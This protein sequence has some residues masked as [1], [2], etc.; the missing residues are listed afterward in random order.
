MAAQRLVVIGG[1]AAGMSAASQARRFRT[2]DELEIVA[3]ER[4]HFA[5]YSACGIPYWIGGQVAG[6]DELIARTPEEHRAR[7]ID[8][9]MRTEVVEIDPDRGRVR[10]RN[11]ES[12]A[13]S[14]TGWDRLVIATG[15]RPVRPPIPGIGAPGVHGV[16]NLDDGQALLGTLET[17]G[18]P[19]GAQ[20]RRR[21]VVVG[22]G[23]I[24]VE[25]AEA[26]LNRGFEVTVLNR[27]EQP[28]ATLDPDM[29]RL[30]HTAMDGLGITTVNRAEV[31]AIRTGDDGR[32]RAVA[33][34]DAEYPADVV[35]LG[36]GVAPE[37]TLARAAGLPTGEHGGLLTDLSMRVRG[38]DAI[39][40]GGDCVEV[41]DLVSG[42]D[43]YIPLGTHANK[44]G[45][46]IGANIGGGYGT[47]P[48]VVGT[49]VSKVC[50]LEIARTGLREK[51]AAAAGL[52]YVTATVES[53]SRAGY[54]P[55][56]SEMT[57][58]ILAERGAG[59][60]LG[61]QIVGR[62]GAAKR[63]D[64]AAV[65]LTA[66][67]TVERMTLLDLGYAPPFSPVWDPVLVAARK[68]VSALT[69]D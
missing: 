66:G 56:A 24:G 21:A 1:D 67:M 55:D 51:D 2:P 23:Y 63:V 40:A 47:F 65:A 29:G 34:A 41:L 10:T 60:L 48:G 64:I 15:A 36:I 69:A 43:R 26:L 5:S 45:Q 61:L 50:D 19:G 37:T 68:A 39:W 58:K 62:E 22:A 6:R 33:T 30:V 32:V 13:E 35:V 8:L 49:A 14:W 17:L 12:G 9:R 59:R 54:Y 31:T 46:I 57:V 42:R 53:T 20:G 38:R 7:G 52:Q 4:G 27:G 11:L 44:H 3:F 16:Q 18:P 25:M 28:M